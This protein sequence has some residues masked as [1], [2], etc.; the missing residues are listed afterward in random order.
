MDSAT[1]NELNSIA[2]ELKS[3][4]N[5]LA[6]IASGVKVDFKNIGNDRCAQAIEKARD[7]YISVR[8]DV[9]NI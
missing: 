9:M 8:K 2:S 4:I 7:K 3:I 1:K 5:E 6:S